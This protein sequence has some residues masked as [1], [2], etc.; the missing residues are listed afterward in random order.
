[1]KKCFIDFE[2]KSQRIYNAG[3]VLIEKDKITTYNF[4][5]KENKSLIP[6][7]KYRKITR[8][9]PKRILLKDFIKLLQDM[10]DD[11]VVFYSYNSYCDMMA[12][13]NT[14]KD[15]G[16]QLKGI[17]IKCLW[18]LCLGTLYLQKRYVK[19][20]TFNGQVRTTLQDG[21]KYAKSDIQLKKHIAIDDAIACY[22]LYERIAKL[23]CKKQSLEYS[24]YLQVLR[25][26][27]YI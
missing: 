27:G 26:K 10:S 25:D 4:I 6:P 7:K 19:S 21:F 12:L 14:L 2:Y 24:S 15:Y 1:M 13:E 9:H 5:I 23:H 18:R 22:Y 3:L 11:K 8:A 16:L 20:H 17:E